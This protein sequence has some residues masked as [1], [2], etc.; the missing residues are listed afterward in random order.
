[1]NIGDRVKVINLKNVSNKNIRYGDIGRI[2]TYQYDSL[3]GAVSDNEIDVL[4]WLDYCKNYIQ[5]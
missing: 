2:I 4:V 3:V 1:M 5:Q